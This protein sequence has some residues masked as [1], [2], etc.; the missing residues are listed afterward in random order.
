MDDA[1]MT[2]PSRFGGSGTTANTFVYILWACLRKPEIATKLRA[3][4]RENFPEPTLV[5]DYKVTSFTIIETI[6]AC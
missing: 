1:K 5:P 2:C 4:L 3:E 6:I